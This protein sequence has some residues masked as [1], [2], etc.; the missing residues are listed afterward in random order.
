MQDILKWG[1]ETF[2][3][4]MRGKKRVSLR[5][6]AGR[7]RTVNKHFGVNKRGR[8]PTSVPKQKNKEPITKKMELDKYDEEFLA[9]D[10]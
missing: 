1:Q 3:I 4:P 10:F 5:S 8:P 2:G 6:I 9:D 7:M